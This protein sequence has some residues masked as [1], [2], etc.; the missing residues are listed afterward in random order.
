MYAGTAMRSVRYTF[1]A[2]HS[3]GSIRTR[4]RMG[5]LAVDV[6]GDPIL[7]RPGHASAPPPSPARA[8]HPAGRPVP[9]AISK[10]NSVKSALADD[11]ATLRPA[12]CSP[13]YVV[14]DR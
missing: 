4:A 9:T 10:P 7:L 13:C 5:G 6:F 1:A 2:D 12:H 14:Q 8:G 11:G 3:P